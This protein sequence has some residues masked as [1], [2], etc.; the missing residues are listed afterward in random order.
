VSTSLGNPPR[1]STAIR[2]LR[3]VHY[4]RGFKSVRRR[5]VTGGESGRTRTGES[6]GQQKGKT[7]C[8]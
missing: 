7:P 4:G 1:T 5:V 3:V 2:K 6:R 8:D